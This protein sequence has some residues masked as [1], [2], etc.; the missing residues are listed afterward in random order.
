MKFNRSIAAPFCAALLLASSNAFAQP[1][2]LA[3]PVKA[4]E[5]PN[6]DMAPLDKANWRALRVKN[7]PPSLIAYQLDGAHNALPAFLNVPWMPPPKYAANYQEP[8]RVEGP[9]DLPA[10]VQL[11]A[12]DERDLLF[13]AGTD[14]A[15]IARLQEL[16]LMLDQPLRHVEIVAR[17]IELPIAELGE[18]GLDRDAATPDALQTGFVRGDFQESINELV[19]AGKARVVSTEPLTFTNNL[20]RAISLRTGPIDNT[21]AGQNKPLVAPKE[22]TD[23]VITLTPTINGDD[24]ITVLMRT[25]ILPA[26]KESSGLIN[27]FNLRDGQTLALSGLPASAFPREKSAPIP[28]VPLL[29]EIPMINS[30]PQQSV[31]LLGDDPLVGKLFRSK[32]ME[33]ERVVLLL[34]TARIVRGDEQN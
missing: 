34:V 1:D 16:V 13:V 10:G 22:G 32:K 24:T 4:Q 9:F 30:T 27:I 7:V 12:S 20:G 28:T 33:D 31:P 11:A 26:T 21:G 23:T 15:Q 6:P 19:A 5:A 8:E 18:F 14:A 2:A 29:G 25:S 17:M 3:A